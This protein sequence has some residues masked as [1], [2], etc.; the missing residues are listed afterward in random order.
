MAESASAAGVNITPI[1]APADGYWSD[2]WLV[3][4]WSGS[5][6]SG[7]PTEDWM[8][9]QGYA[10]ESSWNESYWQNERFNNLLVEARGE[11][12]ND[13]RR[14]MYFE[15]QAICRDDCPSV[16]HL[17]ANHNHGIP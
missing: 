15:M 4:P 9:S 2:V 7:R 17:F 11:L 16:I 8:F 1:R 5:Y 12:D 10:A 6:W 14:D 13:K 3:A